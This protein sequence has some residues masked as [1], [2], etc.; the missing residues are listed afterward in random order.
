[1]PLAIVVIQF[2]WAR[3]R[4]V[5]LAAHPIPNCIRIFV[6]LLGDTPMA[7]SDAQAGFYYQNVVAAG[8]VLE[9]LE[10]GTSVKSVSLESAERAKFVDDIIVERD[11]GTVFVQVKWANDDSATLTLHNL[12]TAD[13]SSEVALIAK[14]AS[15][16]SRVSGE[17]GSKEIVL[18]STRKAGS[19][20]QPAKGF[21]RSLEEF[22]S[23]VQEPLTKGLPSADIRENPRFPEY[24]EIVNQLLQ[25]SGLATFE[26]FNTFLRHLRFRLGQPD[27]ISRENSVRAKLTRL[28]IAQ[29]QYG[30]LLNQV[31]KWSID[32]ANVKVSNV[33]DALGLATHFIDPVDHIF[34]V[35]QEQ[36]VPTPIVFQAL[37]ESLSKLNSGFILLEGEPGIGKST[38]LAEYAMQRPDDV[39]FAY[40]CHVPSDPSLGNYRLEQAAFVRSMCIGLSKAFPDLEF[41]QPYG[42]FS[43]ELLN[44]WLRYVS[45]RDERVVF[46]I[47]GLDHVH[48]KYA[49]HMIREPL[50][51]VLDH[52][53]PDNVLMVLSSQYLAALPRSVRDHIASDQLRHIK[54]PRFVQAQVKEFLARRGVDLEP[55]LLVLAQEVSGGVPIYLEYLGMRLAALSDY[56]REELLKH[57][58]SLSSETID[59]YH[60]HLWRS[61]EDDQTAIYALAILAIRHEFTTP[62]DMAELLERLH[63]P[64]NLLSVEQALRTTAHVL[65]NSEGRGVA[66]RH[67]SFRE[68]VLE[69]TQALTTAINETLVDWYAAHPDRDEAWRHRFRHLFQLGKYEELKQQLTYDWFVSSWTAHRPVSEIHQNID[70]AWQA[71]SITQDLASFLRLALIKQ[72]LA[73]VEHHLDLKP[74]QIARF[75]VDTG[76]DAEAIRTVWDGERAHCGP[77]AFAEFCLHY[78]ERFGSPPPLSII[79]TVLTDRPVEASSIDL[80][81]YYRAST[82]VQSAVEILEEISKLSWTI[83]PEH[84][85]TRK[86]VSD[87]DRQATNL[88]L[89]FAVIRELCNSKNLP[90]LD[91]IVAGGGTPSNEVAQF[92]RV[93]RALLLVRVGEMAEARTAASSVNFASIPE[94]ER[95]TMLLDLADSGMW[96]TVWYTDATAPV[97]PK[98]FLRD[99]LYN[100]LEPELFTIYD[101]FR[102]YFL[103]N[104]EAK[105]WFES[106]VTGLPEPIHPVIS[107]LGELA[108]VWTDWVRGGWKP[109]NALPRLEGILSELDLRSHAFDG[110]G[111]S[112]FLARSLYRQESPRLFAIV[113]NVAARILKEDDLQALGEWW[114]ESNEGRRAVNNSG[115]TKDFAACLAMRLKAAAKELIRSLLSIVERAAR[116]DEET[117]VLASEILAT[118]TAWG[119]C[120]FNPEADRLWRE[121]L[122]LACGVNY[123][124]DY[125]FNEILSPLRFAHDRNPTATRQR[126][127][128]QLNLAHR[129]GDAARAK[130]SAV[131]IEDLIVFARHISPGLPLKMLAHLED[132][133]YRERALHS[134]VLKWINSADVPLTWLWALASTAARWDDYSEYRDHV[135]PMREAIF[136]AALRRKDFVAA[137]TIYRDAK[138]VFLV[139]KGAPQELAKWARLWIEIGDAPAYVQGDIQSHASD[140]PKEDSKET[141]PSRSFSGDPA[142]FTAA[143]EKGV[144][145]LQEVLNQLARRQMT[146][147]WQNEIERVLPDLLEI[148]SAALGRELTTDERTNVAPALKATQNRVA[149]LTPSDRIQTK[150]AIRLAMSDMIKAIAEKFEPPQLAEHLSNSLDMESWLE[151]LPLVFTSRVPYQYDLEKLLPDWIAAARMSDLDS[152]IELCRTRFSDS[153]KAWGLLAIAR[154]IRPLDP[155]RAKALLQEAWRSHATLFFE[156]TELSNAI[157]SE[158][159]SVDPKLGCET[160]LDAFIV[161]H[162]QFPGLIVQRLDRILRF[163]DHFRG[164]DFDEIYNLWAEYNEHLVRG[165]S[166]PPLNLD[167]FL[168]A[169]DRPLT[170]EIL[171]YVLWLL[172]YPVVDV[173]LLA[174]GELLRLLSEGV[175]TPDALLAQWDTFAAAQ[176]ELLAVLF[177]SFGLS[178]PEASHSWA[179]S[180]LKLKVQEPHFNLRRTVSEAILTTNDRGAQLN[181]TLLDDARRLCASP[182]VARP[183]RTPLFGVSS[184]PLLPYPRW[185][186]AHLAKSISREPLLRLIHAR[187]AERYPSREEGFAEEMATHRGY[188]INDNFD[189]IEISGTYDGTVRESINVVLDELR[190]AQIL[191]DVTANN[192]ADLLRVSDPTEPLIQ[193]TTPPPFIK[194]IDTDIGDVEFLSF[195]DWDH[196]ARAFLDRHPAWYTLFE[197]TEQRTGGEHGPLRRRAT[198]VRALVVAVLVDQVIPSADNVRDAAIEFRNRYRFELRRVEAGRREVLNPAIVPLVQA[199]TRAFRGR[200]H[201]DIAA[202]RPEFA[203]EL[204]LESDEADWLGY[205]RDC[206]AAVRST[207]W[208]EAF[209]QSRRR[210]EPRSSGF[211]LEASADTLTSLATTHGWTYWVQLNVERT[212][213]EYEPESKIT[214]SRRSDLF[215]LKDFPPSA[216]DSAR[217]TPFL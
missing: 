103:S 17:P 33:L 203:R 39:T 26:E 172:K 217:E 187:V 213:N 60:R 188:N 15:G 82:Y 32:S 56:E 100:Q 215:R 59:A 186:M 35:V 99:Q 198:R 52:L 137:E 153:C 50:T 23:D 129:L 16:F 173:R 61:L 189:P 90:E 139:E 66:I 89:Q 48:A 9:L 24:K 177:F 85:F 38:L 106:V 144:S 71:A 163:A 25:A 176:K 75:L 43:L 49:Q 44:S 20:R 151:R 4:P 86:Q 31:V 166:A 214:W 111:H 116:S 67:N 175:T 195:N 104:K 205:S 64:A 133:I 13:E 128:D 154:R 91:R 200:H 114:A 179:N 12:V 164:V 162:K 182:A 118:A 19:N 1:M 122:D 2:A 194:W 191:D 169:A 209:D 149:G 97:L 65:R 136:E 68:F 204:G 160:L 57:Q 79:K 94:S 77:V 58:P 87:P 130:T 178:K 101:R 102:F 93:A 41:P 127:A 158:I 131:A 150:A 157:L 171:G 95:R 180:L 78:R 54:V 29:V 207:A 134:L 63:V 152:W 211:L 8:Y 202:L 210:H 206:R 7:G 117:S 96:D 36:W 88:A 156:Y 69:Q 74:E 83:R 37:D 125:Q 126:I 190:Q 30:T 132:S 143:A 123:R 124:K 193:L 147:R 201:L 55:E 53:P 183:L 108:L 110:L 14:L 197:H 22:I 161:Q 70:L 27:L 115:A 170:D 212:T 11:G 167:W 6:Q 10:I 135:L 140:A 34:P 113:W 18:L 168:D 120:G 138:H 145:E 216:P 196:L 165:L 192:V 148:V 72:R 47:D 3:T 141:Q 105:A 80:A 146:E 73:L 62:A 51:S 107:A 142:I 46:L 76:L 181:S 112:N 174:V 208:Q 184:I 109:L 5:H 98:G 121:L 119:M 42:E 92:A 21:P 40:R 199:S 28:G 45:E 84:K 185:M 159:M 81:S 155:E